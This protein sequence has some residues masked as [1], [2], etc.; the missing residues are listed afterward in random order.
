MLTDG[1]VRCWGLI[2]QS[3]PSEPRPR[4]VKKLAAVEGLALG[5]DTSYAWH[6][7]G[8][9]STWDLELG[10]QWLYAESVD[11]KYDNIRTSAVRVKGID[12]ARALAASSTH[13]CALRRGGTLMCW[14]SGNRGQ[15]G[16]GLFGTEYFAA[17]PKPVAGLTDLSCVA[18]GPSFTCVCHTSGQ[19]SCW[20][21]NE[22]GQLGLGDKK[23][24]LKPEL[25]A[26]LEHITSLAVGDDHTCALRRDGV[27]YCWGK[28]LSGQIGDGEKGLPA[29]RLRPVRIDVG[30]P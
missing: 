25:V 4:P 15:L 18:V 16:D 9:V 2:A 10:K 28:N 3:T 27:V 29:T 20:G 6:S 14:G 19:V 13:V 24:R 17:K 26:G 23:G 21:R 1:T 5:G 30:A 11:G 22:W 8:S 7:D 12:D